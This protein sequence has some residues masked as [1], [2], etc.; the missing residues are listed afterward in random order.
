MAIID[1]FR[2]IHTVVVEIDV[3]EGE[4]DALVQDLRRFLEVVKTQPGFVSANIHKSIDGK[5]LINY[6]QWLN[7]E[8]FEQ[9]KNNEDIQKH[10]EFLEKH[11]TKTIEMKVV[12]AT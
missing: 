10:A 12:I 11:D 2:N 9:F 6:A 7:Q 4:T 5:K 1:Q 3:K 8:S